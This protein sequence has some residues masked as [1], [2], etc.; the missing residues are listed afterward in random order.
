MMTPRFI[1][2]MLS[3]SLL[4]GAGVL[5]SQDYPSK[6]IR[7]MVDAIGSASDTTARIMAPGISGPLGQQV[8]VE[9]RPGTTS[10]ETVAKSPPDGYTLLIDG[11]TFFI[12]PLLRKVPYDVVRDYAPISVTTTSVNVLV[13]HPALPV[14]SVK[15]LIALAKAR[16]GELSYT[17]GGTGATSHLAAE[18]FKSMAG[19]NIVRI[20]YSSGT[21]EMTD[22]M[23]G[24]VPLSFGGSGTVTQHIKTGRLKAIAVTS[25]QP[26]ALFP[27]LPTISESGLPGYD[28]S[29]FRG[30]MAP[31]KTP[32]PI[33]NRLNQEI[34]RFFARPDVQ[35]RF[36]GVGMEVIG[37]TPEGLA[38]KI[39]GDVTKW[40]K[41][42]KELGIKA[43]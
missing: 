36:I 40:G 30:I 8:I 10:P 13:V 24:N 20:P 39:Q 6:P 35:E 3:V 33:I 9:N 23:S 19:V 25:A 15:E 14:K 2:G 42:I 16:P 5:R 29:G 12:A 18:L 38:A 1:V 31:A 21:L 4:F 34:V 11:G 26:S 22:L 17:S 27:G 32:V 28:A 37:T 7:I 41:L 43:D